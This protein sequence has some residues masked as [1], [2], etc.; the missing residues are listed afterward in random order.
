[1]SEEDTAG[2]GAQFDIAQGGSGI[3]L[4]SSE[5]SHMQSILDE[6]AA[7]ESAPS[8]GETSGVR[9]SQEAPRKTSNQAHSTTSSQPDKE[10]S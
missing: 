1:M 7:I 3:G 2:A 5:D 4:S 8:S 9:S 10:P 6:L